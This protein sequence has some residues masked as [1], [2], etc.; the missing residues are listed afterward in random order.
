MR[1]HRVAQTRAAL[2][3][4]LGLVVVV[5]RLERT[6][7]RV[8]T[9]C[10]VAVLPDQDVTREQLPD[11]AEDRERPRD[12]VEREERVERVEVDLALRQRVELGRE[13]ELAVD[14]AVVERLDPEAVAREHELLLPRIPDRDGE[15]PAQ[16]LEEAETPLFVAVHVHLGVAL[17]A[18]G[19]AGAP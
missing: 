18:E 6:W 9:Y 3:D 2:L 16:P 7:P 8:F 14:V 13:R 11:L 17:G 1:A 15:H 19:V 4:E 12:R 5:P 10:H